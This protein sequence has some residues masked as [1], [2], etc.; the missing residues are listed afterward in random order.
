MAAMRTG[1]LA[2]AQAPKGLTASEISKKKDDK[3]PLKKRM[4]RIH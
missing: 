3:K 4:I 2:C 1:G